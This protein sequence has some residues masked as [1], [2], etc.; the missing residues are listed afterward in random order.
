MKKLFTFVFIAILFLG[1]QKDDNPLFRIIPS[2]MTVTVDEAMGIF[3]VPHI[4]NRQIETN[5]LNAFNGYGTHPD[6]IKYIRP[7]RARLSVIFQDG[8]MDFIRAMS[9]RICKLG[10]D[11]FSEC[12]LEAFWRDPAP[13]NTRFD[14]NLN[15][16]NVDDLRELIAQEKVNVQ[17]LFEKLNWNPDRTIDIQIELEFGVW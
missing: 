4:F 2:P 10:E 1:C 13:D 12:G 15:T 9:I 5:Y 6:S 3:G 7:T 16:S 14:L 17:I 8:R 11:N